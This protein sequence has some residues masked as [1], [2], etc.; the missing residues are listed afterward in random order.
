M[1]AIYKGQCFCGA[2][3]VEVSGTP[4]AMSYCHCESCR[5]WSGSP[6]HASTLWK[7]AAV[8]V[9]VGAEHIHTFQKTPESISHRQFCSKCGGHL[10]ISHPTF[11]IFDVHAATIPTLQFVPSLHVNYSETV[12]PMRD[13]LPKYQ[14]FPNEFGGSGVRVT[15]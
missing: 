3:Q 12:L 6:V 10:M 7:S 2:V 14:D 1:T 4:E 5:S 9:I 15:E 13:G 11:G 8:R